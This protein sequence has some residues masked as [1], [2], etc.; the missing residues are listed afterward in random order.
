MEKTVLLGKPSLLVI[1]EKRILPVAPSAIRLLKKNIKIK[2]N[3]L[4]IFLISVKL[5][6]ENLCT[7]E[8]CFQTR[9]K[10]N[11]R[12]ITNAF[13]IRL[14]A[15]NHR[16]ILILSTSELFLII[17]VRFITNHTKIKNYLN[18]RLQSC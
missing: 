13:N 10:H 5:F 17:H 6:S 8:S 14:L 11:I 7:S 15:L 12:N 16:L 9:V 1:C 2:P 3:H 4:F 18:A